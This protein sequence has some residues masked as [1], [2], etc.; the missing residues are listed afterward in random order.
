VEFGL[1]WRDRS[2]SSGQTAGSQ[3]ARRFLDFMIDGTSLYESHGMDFIS[4]LGWLSPDDDEQAAERLILKAGPELDGRVA[5]YICPECGELDCGAITAKIEREG[6]ELVWREMSFSSI[7]WS[8]EV[9]EHDPTDFEELQE[10]RFPAAEYTK[11][12]L[13][14]PA[15]AD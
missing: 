5:L 12:I 4:V 8:D 15:P 1:E 14:R 7:D 10:L 2:V 9:W 13:A 3:T 11:A 6:D